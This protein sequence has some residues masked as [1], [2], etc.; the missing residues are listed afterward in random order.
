MKESQKY[1]IWLVR[2]WINY[3]PTAE[4]DW[5]SIPEPMRA[6][7]G[8][9]YCLERDEML[10]AFAEEPVLMMHLAR[11]VAG[12]ET[13]DKARMGEWVS[14]MYGAYQGALDLFKREWE[15][16]YE[17]TLDDSFIGPVNIDHEL[18]TQRG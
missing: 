9:L 10:D 7:L 3:D 17:K 6:K 13:P 2:N 8:A 4:A 14:R 5:W 18:D 1:A 11:E 15:R 16:E 12:T